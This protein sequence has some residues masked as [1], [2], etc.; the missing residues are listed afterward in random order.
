MDLA[1]GDNPRGTGFDDDVNRL[2][3]DSV[4][5]GDDEKA[6]IGGESKEVEC[7]ECGHLFAP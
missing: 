6:G 3:D 1:A 7:P 2:I 5:H 4:P